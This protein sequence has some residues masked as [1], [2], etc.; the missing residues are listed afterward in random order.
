ML[1]GSLSC[2]SAGLRNRSIDIMSTAAGLAD[3]SCGGVI[4][5]GV[6]DLALK[7]CKSAN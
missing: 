2:Y 3:L 7:Y 6:A 5:E 4:R 1:R